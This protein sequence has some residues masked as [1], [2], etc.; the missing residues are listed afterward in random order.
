[1]NAISRKLLTLVGFLSTGL[2][3]LGIFLPLVPTTPF[4]LVAAYC[5]ARSSD[6]HYQRLLDNRWFGRY[7]RDYRAGRIRRFERRVTLAVMWLVIGAVAYFVLSAWWARGL[8]LLIPTCVTLFLSRF[9][10]YEDVEDNASD[11]TLAE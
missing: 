8:L 11:A 7:I 2:G 4:L 6:R 5:F 10:T 1:M 3:F 9:E